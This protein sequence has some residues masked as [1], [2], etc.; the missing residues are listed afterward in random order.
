MRKLLKKM[1][2]KLGGTWKLPLIHDQLSDG[3]YP[4]YTVC[5]RPV[6]DNRM[7][8]RGTRAEND[9]VRGGQR[10]YVNVDD[11]VCQRPRILGA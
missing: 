11:A 10:I 8:R 3:E 1:E 7:R 9:S 2:L 4:K 6:L 5:V